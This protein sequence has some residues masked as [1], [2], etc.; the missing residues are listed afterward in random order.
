[1]TK[2]AFITGASRGI[3]RAIARRFAAEG[4]AVVL[5]AS[6]LGVHGKRAGTL[7]EAVEEIQAAGGRAAA[8]VGDLADEAARADLIER[9]GEAFGPI[10]VLVNNAAGAR[11]RLPSESTAEER[12]LMF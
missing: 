8:V 12:P 3:G 6:R 1:M 2:T 11:M 5:S 10:D 7:Q 9:S 4:A